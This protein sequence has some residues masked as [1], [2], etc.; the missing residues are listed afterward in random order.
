MIIMIMIIVVTIAQVSMVYKQQ[1]TGK[2]ASILDPT[3]GVSRLLVKDNEEKSFDETEFYSQDS[4]VHN[5]IISITV[6]KSEGITWHLLL[7]QICPKCAP[8]IIKFIII[9]SCNL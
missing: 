4:L 7:K 9:R 2:A 6:L 8:S 3:T 1:Q 5:F